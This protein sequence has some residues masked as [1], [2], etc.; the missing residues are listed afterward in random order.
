MHLGSAA[1]Y[2]SKTRVDGW[3]GAD[4]DLEI[5][6]VTLLGYDRFISERQFGIKR[7]MLLVRADDDLF[8]AYPVIRLPSNEVYLVG[9]SNSDVSD[10][11]YSKVYLIHR[12]QGIGTLYE[13]TQ[14]TKASGMKGTA[15]RAGLGSYWCDVERVTMSN[16]KEFDN[17]VFSQ[18]TITL[19]RGCPVNT[20]QELF[21]DGRYLTIQ[22]AVEDSGFKQCRGIAKRSA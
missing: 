3:N 22:E 20:D 12:A 6:S 1:N 8:P 18:M 17:V 10:D 5:A 4:W 14:T 11:E 9:E 19:P 21:M 16:S 15:V 2:F 7:R 13:F